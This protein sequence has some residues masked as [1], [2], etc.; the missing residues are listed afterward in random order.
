MNQGEFNGHQLLQ[1]E[2]VALMHRPSRT[3]GGDFMQIGYGYGWGI[4][5][6]EPRQMWDI[7][8]QP[9]GYQG[10]GGSYLGYSSTMFMVEE[11]GG[12]Y[13]YVLLFNTGHFGKADWPWH[14]STRLNIGDLILGEAYQMYQDLHIQ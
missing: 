12:A 7:T 1:P 4:Y 5:Q 11:E 3:S 9:R 2:T 14:F 13:G 6:K 8:F 10:H